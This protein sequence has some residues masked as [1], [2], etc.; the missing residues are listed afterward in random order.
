MFSL[1]SATTGVAAGWMMMWVVLVVAS[2]IATTSAQVVELTS[3]TFE[4]QTQA[5]TGQTTGKWF[6]KFFAPWC[7]HCKRL[8]PIWK[9]TSSQ[10]KEDEMFADAGIVM[11]K[12]DCTE[13][14]D[15]CSRFGVTGYPTLKYIADGQVFTYKGPRASDDLLEF[16]MEGYKAAKGEPVPA[17]PSWF[18]ELLDSNQFV[19]SL[20]NDLDHIVEVRKNAAA[21]VFVLGLIWGALITLGL[22]IVTSGSNSAGA[23]GDVSSSSNKKKGD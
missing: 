21:L 23:G 10:L 22:G 9:E 6:V 16:A 8:D 17:P 7:G 14:M 19:K 2:T 20:I 3:A 11:A 5:S 18:E 4:H 1:R 15:V 13:S 12:V